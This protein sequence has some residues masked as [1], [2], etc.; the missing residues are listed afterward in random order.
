M[1]RSTAGYEI[2]E[3][4][5]GPTL[6]RREAMA[7]GGAGLAAFSLRQLFG[8]F[9]R[10]EAETTRHNDEQLATQ[11]FA[12]GLQ[13]DW[14]KV[15][16]FPGL[17]VIDPA[18]QVYSDVSLAAN[19]KLTWTTTSDQPILASR[20]FFVKGSLATYAGKYKKSTNQSLARIT[21]QL[22]NG[23][24]ALWAPGPGRL[25]YFDA[26]KSAGLITPIYRTA[27]GR[28]ATDKTDT[29]IKG[30]DI[31]IDGRE[32]WGGNPFL[33]LNRSHYETRPLTAEEQALYDRYRDQD[34]DSK[35]RGLI[36]DVLSENRTITTTSRMP[37]GYSMYVNDPPTLGNMIATFQDNS[38]YEPI[39]MPNLPK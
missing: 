6:T 35:T 23:L 18:I 30:Q 7:M 28:D 29:L 14:D 38:G 24:V 12:N 8:Y 4:D 17:L 36:Y 9:G 5:L 10:R 39:G 32:I 25:V 34:L 21:P 3:A 13:S 27:A 37:L 15:T 19:K 2:N 22:P 31:T 33:Y 20:P 26:H 16:V 1:A 11:A